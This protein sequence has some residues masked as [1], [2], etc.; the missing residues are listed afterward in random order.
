MPEILKCNK[1]EQFSTIPVMEETKNIFYDLYSAYNTV[2]DEDNYILLN[3][4]ISFEENKNL[5]IL[6]LGNSPSTWENEL[7]VRGEIIGTGDE[8]K[9]NVCNY[10]DDKIEILPHEKLTSFYVLKASGGDPLIVDELD[11]TERGE[12]GFGSTGLK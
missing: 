3:T 11:E 4:G 1:L 6:I 12:R 5:A 7:A 2:V 8:I 9:L 10:V